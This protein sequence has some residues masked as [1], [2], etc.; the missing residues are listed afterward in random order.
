MVNLIICIF[1]I[2]SICTFC[3]INRSKSFR[4][5]ENGKGDK[6]SPSL[7]PFSAKKKKKKKKKALCR[8]LRV[9]HDLMPSLILRI[10]L[11]SLPSLPEERSLSQKPARHTESNAL[12]KSTN[13]QNNFSF[14]VSKISINPCN[15]NIWS[16]NPCES[17]REFPLK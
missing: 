1:N 13:V 14:R 5:R 7:S 15:T 11:R 4:K 16:S 9:T 10:T 6:F 12:L 17:Q 2:S 3:T 8:P